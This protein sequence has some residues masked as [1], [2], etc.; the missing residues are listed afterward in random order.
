MHSNMESSEAKRKIEV[1][2]VEKKTV[3]VSLN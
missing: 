1:D 2:T 3:G